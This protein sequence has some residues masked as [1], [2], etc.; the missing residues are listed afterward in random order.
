[1]TSTR[2]GGERYARVLVIAGC[3]VV[4]SGIVLFAAASLW[5]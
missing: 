3:A 4:W 1:M 5:G 2:S